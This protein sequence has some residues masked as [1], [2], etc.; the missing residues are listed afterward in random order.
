MNLSHKNKIKH[1]NSYIPGNKKSHNE[2]LDFSTLGNIKLSENSFTEENEPISTSFLNNSFGD[3]DRSK[4]N[5]KN[6]ENK[7]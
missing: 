1:F 6:L 7:E 5:L 4:D 3:W 2:S